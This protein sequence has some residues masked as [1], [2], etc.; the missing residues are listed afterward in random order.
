MTGLAV[1]Q[2][3]PLRCNTNRSLISP[4]NKG[5]Q[6]PR[7]A[8]T[9]AGFLFWDDL[10]ID[11]FVMAITSAEAI[12]RYMLGFS[13]V[14]SPMNGRTQMRKTSSFAVCPKCGAAVR[15]EACWSCN[16]TAASWTSVCENCGG[17]G[18]LLLCPNRTCHSPPPPDYWRGLEGQ[19]S[20]PFLC[21][22]HP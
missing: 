12:V 20:N 1:P 22:R 4:F 10:R 19:L 3:E 6:R 7:L 5:S 18:Q 8:R 15:S 9:R 13:W 11:H 17:R 14:E 21:R 16:G 2:S